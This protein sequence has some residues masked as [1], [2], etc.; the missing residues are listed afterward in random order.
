M[1]YGDARTALLIVLLA[2]CVMAW[3][4][5]ADSAEPARR[6]GVRVL[7]TSEEVLKTTPAITFVGDAAG[8]ALCP[9]YHGTNPTEA[10]FDVLVPAGVDLPT[11]RVAWDGAT[12]EKVYVGH[13]RVPFT[14]DGEAVEFRLADDLRVPYA[15]HTSWADVPSCRLTY[16][17]KP[18]WR[19]SGPHLDAPWHDAAARA[20]GN[21]MFGAREVF[22]DLNITDDRRDFDG[23]I[24][25][26]GYENT[27]PRRMSGGKP[28][29]H[30]DF[31]AHLHLFLVLSP[32]WRIRQA[33]HFYIAPDGS[34]T[35]ECR[36]SPSACDDPPA[37]YGKGEFSEQR[38]FEGRTAFL[39][40][41]SEE[42]F[43]AIRRGD[44]AYTVR[45][46]FGSVS[47]A[48]GVDIYKGGTR[49]AKVAVEDDCRAGRMTIRRTYYDNGA[50]RRVHEDVLTYDPDLGTELSRE[51]REQPVAP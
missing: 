31:P 42:G 43:L 15:M 7:K 34:L 3:G 8:C 13:T 36:C 41:V 49:I 33:T 22:R 19:R 23:T 24:H 40:G 27:F 46:P 14:V 47:F 2:L 17:H 50:A 26:V 44:E 30:S 35:G 1:I 10:Y 32:G 4:L 11:L 25:I 20:E 39:V 21:L 28:Y 9:D 38:D 6:I 48:R 5:C 51:T 18:S 37:R 12:V 29:G 16:M 45:P